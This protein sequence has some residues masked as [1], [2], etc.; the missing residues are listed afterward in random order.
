[1]NASQKRT[2]EKNYLLL[3][4]DYELP[5]PTF[6]EIPSKLSDAVERKEVFSEVEESQAKVWILL[7]DN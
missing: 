6:P 1:M 7:G 2:I 5:L 4:D 3:V